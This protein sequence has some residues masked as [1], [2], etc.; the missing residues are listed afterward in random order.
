MV[1]V[2]SDWLKKCFSFFWTFC[3]IFAASLLANNI[4]R[5]NC[6]FAFFLHRLSVSGFRWQNVATSFSSSYIIR[7]CKNLEWKKSTY[8]TFF[9]IGFSPDD[10]LACK[11]GKRNIGRWIRINQP[12]TISL[13]KLASNWKRKG[14]RTRIVL[15]LISIMFKYF[16]TGSSYFGIVSMVTL[17]CR[18]KKIWCYISYVLKR[19]CEGCSENLFCLFWSVGSLI[20]YVGECV[21][22][23]SE[24]I[25]N[26]QVTL[27]MW[28]D[29]A[30]IE[31]I[32]ERDCYLIWNAVVIAC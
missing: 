20:W 15:L 12:K 19:R 28:S 27:I 14:C 21:F 24:M 29:F 11:L 25:V 17:F 22:W 16:R 31:L 26:S 9:R 7:R 13:R 2:T 5:E 30:E 10:I 23:F 1:Y 18:D 6:R 8:T 4:N 32:F 3:K